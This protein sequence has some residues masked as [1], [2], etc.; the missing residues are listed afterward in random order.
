MVNAVFGKANLLCFN[1]NE[2][3]IVDF[4][5]DQGIFSFIDRQDLL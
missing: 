2:Q 1:R 5:L 3:A 4:D